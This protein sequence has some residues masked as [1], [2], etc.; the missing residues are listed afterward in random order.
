MDG[1][2]ECVHACIHAYVCVCVCVTTKNDPGCCDGF[3]WTPTPALAAPSM[4]LTFSRRTL[5]W[6]R[7]GWAA[8][9]G[10]W[11]RSRRRC[12]TRSKEW[13]LSARKSPL[14]PPAHTSQRG[15]GT[16]SLMLRHLASF[17]LGSMPHCGSLLFFCDWPGGGGT[18]GMYDFAESANSASGCSFKIF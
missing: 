8:S 15:T 1:F 17:S 10:S 9:S 5:T 13:K 3:Q 11:S 14:L 4:T 2:I 16:V 7:T 6:P 18:S 12:C